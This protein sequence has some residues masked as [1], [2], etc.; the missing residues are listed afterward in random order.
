MR[1]RQ[2]LAS[3]PQ[4][5]TLIYIVSSGATH[6]EKRSACSSVDRQ[7]RGPSSIPIKKAIISFS[8]FIDVGNVAFQAL[9]VIAAHN[10]CQLRCKLLTVDSRAQKNFYSTAFDGQD[11]KRCSK[12]YETAISRFFS[13]RRQQLCL[14]HMT[15]STR[16]TDWCENHLH[17]LFHHFIRCCEIT[18]CKMFMTWVATTK[19]AIIIINKLWRQRNTPLTTQWF[20]IT[21]VP[22]CHNAPKI[23]LFASAQSIVLSRCWCRQGLETLC[24]ICLSWMMVGQTKK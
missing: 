4:Y 12:I 6:I 23:R 14:H 5:V 2:N 17:L 1:G 20:L 11:W 7:W 8:K 16:P 10:G 15:K 18:S 22:E 13:T 19:T 21:K 9:F 24:G 3:S